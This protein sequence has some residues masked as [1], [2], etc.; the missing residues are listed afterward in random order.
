LPLKSSW[1]GPVIDYHVHP[2]FS[3]DAS[4]SM[5]DC[6]KAAI[7]AGVTELCFTTH[8]E[9][10]PA[11]AEI[12]CVCVDG[13]RVHVASDWA[14]AYFAEIE[15]CRVEF[16]ALTIR[17]GVEVGYEPG[18]EGLISDFLGAHEFDFVLGAIHCLD[19]IAITAGDE[20]EQFKR[21]YLPYGPEHVAGRYFQHIRAAAGSQLFDCLAHLD[22]YRK[23]I[24]PLFDERFDAVIRAE[25]GP[26]LR[27][28]AESGTGIEV[29]SS[30][31]RRGMN[32]PYPAAV[33]VEQAVQAGVLRF[34]VGSDAHRAED[35][36]KGIDIVTALFARFG[37][38]PARFCQR[39]PVQ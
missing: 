39:K 27:F 35:V 19:H 16:P 5:R 20:L 8:Y 17:A 18:L 34:T 24:K 30:A 6:C 10:D 13:A 38:Q 12:E 37:I 29:N 3:P 21:D 23:Y 32:E 36:G 26:T 4:G 22:V 25:L 28:I 2:D 15:R 7:A 31:L 33:I 9:P 14:S 1:G 11:R